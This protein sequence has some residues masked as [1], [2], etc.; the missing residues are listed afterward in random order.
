MCI[1]SIMQSISVIFYCGLY[2]AQMIIITIID[3]HHHAVI[4]YPYEY[5]LFVV[6]I[7]LYLIIPKQPLFIIIMY[8]SIT[9]TRVKY[10]SIVV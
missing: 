6:V 4:L 9:P 2:R 10:Y 3:H 8:D 5:T 7:L 1:W